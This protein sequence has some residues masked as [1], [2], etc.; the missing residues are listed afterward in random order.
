MADIESGFARN[1]G[2]EE[3][4]TL[5]ESRCKTHLPLHSNGSRSTETDLERKKD[6]YGHFVLRLAFC[7]SLVASI[8]V[9]S[10]LMIVLMQRGTSSKIFESRINFI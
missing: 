6:Q 8:F 4:K 9:C 5:V 2:Y 10:I 3:I 1:R 7:R